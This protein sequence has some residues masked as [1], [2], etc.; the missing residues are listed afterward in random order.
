MNNDFYVVKRVNCDPSN[1]SD[2][3]KNELQVVSFKIEVLDKYRSN[4]NY[5]L[6]LPGNVGTLSSTQPAWSLQLDVNDNSG[7]VSTW[8]YKIGDLPD[9][10]QKH[11]ADH[12]IS[13]RELSQIAY[14]RWVLG[15]P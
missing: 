10:D 6:Y 2:K 1:F 3:E 8:L 12:N 4:N 7:Y 15:Q 13:P 9:S 11:F 5:E 14:Q